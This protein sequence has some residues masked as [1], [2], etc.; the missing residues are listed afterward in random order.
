MFKHSS[1]EV[2]FRLYFMN[3]YYLNALIN[4]VTFGSVESRKITTLVSFF[5]YN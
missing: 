5:I 3:Y 2:Y 1:M 4:Y